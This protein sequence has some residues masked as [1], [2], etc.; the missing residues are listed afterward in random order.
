MLS[1]SLDDLALF[2]NKLEPLYSSSVVPLNALGAFYS[3]MMQSA[4]EEFE[5]Y[6]SSFVLRESRIPVIFKVVAR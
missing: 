2:N 5:K 4:T 6:L 3:S 1:G